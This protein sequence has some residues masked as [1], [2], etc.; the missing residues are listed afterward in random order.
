MGQA[1]NVTDAKAIAMSDCSSE[2]AGNDA[3]TI[4]V[5]LYRNEV[6]AD[7]AGRVEAKRLWLQTDSPK[8]PKD[9]N[10]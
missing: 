10:A 1:R 8:S 9:K 2:V 4:T 5:S 3:G 6:H 7:G